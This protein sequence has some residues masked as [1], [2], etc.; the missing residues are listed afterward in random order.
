[1]FQIFFKICKEN[2][3]EEMYLRLENLKLLLNLNLLVPKCLK[4]G[5]NLEFKSILRLTFGLQNYGSETEKKFKDLQTVKHT[6]VLK[7]LPFIL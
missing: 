3:L 2:G 6:N 5:Y 1:M 4:F 7:M